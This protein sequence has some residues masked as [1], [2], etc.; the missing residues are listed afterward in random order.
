MRP[1]VVYVDVD[2]TFVRNYGKKRIPMPAVINHVKELKKQ[3]AIL[4]CWS[5]GGAEYARK[6]SIEFG[7]EDCFESFLPKPQVAI[8][9]QTFS[10]WLYLLE[11]H[12]NSIEGEGVVTY[13]E[14]LYDSERRAKKIGV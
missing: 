5:S 1:I 10:D 8:D 2:E 9:D 7:I 3:G 4:Y 6:S 14:Q 11:V 12:P 13:N